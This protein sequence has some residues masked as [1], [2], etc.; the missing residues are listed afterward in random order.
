MKKICS[1]Q[2]LIETV[3]AV[4][5][6]TLIVT[7]LVAATTS[8]LQFSQ[9]SKTRTQA[10]QYAKEGLEIVRIIKDAGWTSIPQTDQSYCLSQ[11]QRE[12]GTS[13]SD[14]CPMDIDNIYS[15][16]L[17]FSHDATCVAP[18]CSKVTVTVSWIENEI[19]SVSLS[20]Y[21]TNWRTR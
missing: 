2:S 8:T 11:G 9:M 6:V 7:G 15:R 1:G 17:S 21:I 14:A 19:T 16:T 10:L 13:T 5:V 18:A 3:V 12:L 4:G 20:S